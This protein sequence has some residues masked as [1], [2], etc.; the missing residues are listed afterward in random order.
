MEIWVTL[1]DLDDVNRLTIVLH[2]RAR[3]FVCMCVQALVY[4]FDI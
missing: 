2:V 4:L 3:V 1:L